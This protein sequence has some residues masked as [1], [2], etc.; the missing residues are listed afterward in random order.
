M[1]YG[2]GGFL[3]KTLIAQLYM[4]IRDITILIESWILTEMRSQRWNPGFRHAPQCHSWQV[5]KLTQHV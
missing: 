2:S 3:S 1:K 5:K 4:Y